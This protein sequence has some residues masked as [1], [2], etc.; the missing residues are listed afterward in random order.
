MNEFP[1]AKFI[2]T[3]V[4]FSDS[5]IHAPNENLDLKF[6]AKLTS[7]VALFLSEL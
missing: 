1:K 5:N 6:C 7:V 2:L 4:C 3:G